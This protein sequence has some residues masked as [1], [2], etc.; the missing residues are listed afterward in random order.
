ML[1]ATRRALSL[2]FGQEVLFWHTFAMT[3]TMQS[4]YDVRSNSIGFL[5]LLFAG[6]VLLSH[7]WVLGNFGNEPLQYGPVNI[8]N[9]AVCGFFA[10]SGLLIAQSAER[11]SLGRFAWHRAIRI[12]PG[13]WVCLLVVSFG[14]A[15]LAYLA[16]HGS[17]TGFLSATDGPL[18]YLQ[19]N[20]T[21]RIQQ[22]GISGTPA[23]LPFPGGDHQVWNGS[24]YT[25]WPEVKC[26]I[27][28]GLLAAAGLLGRIRI[29]VPLTGL[30]LLL[31]LNS[32]TTQLIQQAGAGTAGSHGFPW[33]R[34]RRTTCADW[35]C[36]RAVER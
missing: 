11:F 7:T 3:R 18:R 20:D 32:V 14:F 29:V 9:I 27:A 19:M 13:F 35:P 6:T 25:L 30:A 22:Y 26:Y 34:A 17:L 23:G 4:A 8:G 31:G 21:L 16:Q 1:L 28:M 2:K 24:L 15:P 36:L 12:L 33:W 5:R 10:L